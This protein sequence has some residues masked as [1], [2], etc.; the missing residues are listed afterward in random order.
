L[1]ILVT[2]WL[3]SGTL[4]WLLCET[5]FPESSWCLLVCSIIWAL[6]DWVF[7]PVFVHT[8]L[9]RNLSRL[10][11][12]LFL[13]VT[14]VILALDSIQSPASLWV[15][16]WCAITV[17]D[18][19]GIPSPGSSQICSWYVVQHKLREYLIRDVCPY[20]SFPWGTVVPNVSSIV[21]GLWSGTVESHLAL[22]RI[23]VKYP[24]QAPIL[25]LWLSMSQ[26]CVT[27]WAHT[28]PKR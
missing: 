24:G 7:I 9:S 12:S 21:T 3:I 11:I 2:I 1:A 20:K 17:S 25:H 16:R 27:M 10:L 14:P 5:M 6:K 26:H 4:F 19:E 8:H 18:L 22:E 15:H 13:V 28:P 23:T